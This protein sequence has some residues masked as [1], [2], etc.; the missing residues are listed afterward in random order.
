MQMFERIKRADVIPISFLYFSR[1]FTLLFLILFSLL[2]M[3]FESSVE[4]RCI[5]IYMG[6]ESPLAYKTG[7][8]DSCFLI[9]SFNSLVEDRRCIF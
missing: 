7:G 2:L 8:F 4:L 1:N 3:P 9:S 5:Y 6:S